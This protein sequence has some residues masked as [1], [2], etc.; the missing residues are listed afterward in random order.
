MQFRIYDRQTLAY[1]DGGYVASYT[2]DDDYIVNNNSTINIIKELNN[3]VVV[4]DTIVLIKTS[5]AYHK[6]TITTFDNADF[7]ITYKADK[8]LFNDN[9]LNPYASFFAEE[10]NKEATIAK[11]FGIEDVSNII[12]SYFGRANDWL[13]QLPIK[14]VT[15]GEVVTESGEVKMLWTWK[16]DTI[17]FVDW[18]VELFTSYNLSLSWSIDFNIAEKD[19]TKRKPY[20]IVTLSAITNSGKI[21]KDNVEMQTITYTE[22][23]LPES[24]VCV[25]LDEE[26]KTVYQMNSKKNLLNPYYV[27]ENE[28]LS[29]TSYYEQITED[30]TSNISGFIKIKKDTLYTF[31]FNGYDGKDRYI[32]FY[33]EGKNLLFKPKKDENGN[34]IPETI[35]YN[36]GPKESN[37]KCVWAGFGLKQDGYIKICYSKNSTQVQLEEGNTATAYDGYNIPAIY[38]LCEE[39]GNY[40]VSLNPEEKDKNGLTLRVMPSKLTTATFDTSG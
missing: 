17:N 25:V 33:D 21:I 9:M 16:D 26:T 7:K 14:V 3:K 12:E 19:L 27:K 2:I 22:K 4:G 40:Y 28:F 10:V 24:T 8:E 29:A 1:K 36:F 30:K 15:D 20:Y 34:Y 5:G 38:Y 35:K 39:K 18:L 31:S 6:G 23:K 13:R 37:E 11:R 32:L